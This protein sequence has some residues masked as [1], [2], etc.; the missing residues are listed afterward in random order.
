MACT[1]LFL[2]LYE[3]TTDP[4]TRYVRMESETTEYSETKY[5]EELKFYV[6]YFKT[7]NCNGYYDRVNIT[8][9]LAAFDNE[10]YP[11][12]Q[13]RLHHILEGWNDFRDYSDSN[14][15]CLIFGYEEIT[16]HIFCAIAG[17]QHD[18]NAN[19]Y[20]ILNH[21]ALCIQSDNIEVSLEGLPISLKA[22]PLSKTHGWFA[23]NRRPMR[24]YNQ[25]PKHGENGRGQHPNA[26]PLLCSHLEATEMMH[27]AIREDKSLFWRDDSRNSY[28]KFKDENTAENSYHAY[29]TDTVAQYIVDM[30]N[31][32]LPA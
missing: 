17:R 6:H 12:T 11:S 27:K 18:N 10:F 5:L 24:T 2:L 20:L 22:L 21:D 8:S 23:A 32:L 4:P 30:I 1:E 19:T 15:S 16:D 29:H 31:R 3:T 28:I 7:E 9:H 14:R 13:T 25:N 26:S